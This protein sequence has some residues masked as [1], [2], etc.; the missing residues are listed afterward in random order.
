MSDF[1]GGIFGKVTG[2]ENNASHEKVWKK[3]YEPSRQLVLWGFDYDNNPSFLIL[4]GIQKLDRLL[5]GVQYLK[6]EIIFTHYIVAKGKMGHFPSLD[7]EKA[8][9]RHQEKKLIPQ[10][11]IKL[12]CD[13]LRSNE[14]CV[15]K[16]MDKN[17]YFEDFRLVKKPNEVLGLD[18]QFISYAPCIIEMFSNP[19]LYIR[20]KR[21]SELLKMKPSHELYLFLLSKGSS[22]LISGL[23]LELA[24]EKDPVL[25]D[26]AKQILTSDIPWAEESYAK[27]I[28]R[29][30]QIYSNSLDIALKQERIKWIKKSL[31]ALNLQ[32]TSVYGEELPED[33]VL[34][35]KTY[36][37][38]FNQGILKD[39]RYYYDFAQKKSVP[40]KVPRTFKEG[41]YC[42]GH[43]FSQ[44]LFKNT[45][46]EAEAYELTDV[47]GKLAYYLDSPGLH[48]YL[49]ANNKKGLEY[50]RRYMRRVIDAYAKSNPRKF[51]DIMKELL[52]SYTE[53]DYL[54]K[55]KGSFGFNYFIRYYL[56][57]DYYINRE[58]N[59]DRYQ[60][61]EF[62]LVKYTGDVT[63]FNDRNEYMKGIWDNHLNI[64][65]EIACEAKILPVIKACYCILAYS[66]NIHE[67]LANATYEQLIKLASSK[68]EPLSKA[69]C[70]ILSHKINQIYIFDPKLMLELLS[71]NNEK[72]HELAMGY[73][74]R[75]NASFTP[76]TIAGFL[77]LENMGQWFDIFKENLLSFKGDNYGAFVEQV[78]KQKDEFIEKNVEISKEVEDVLVFSLN[79]AEDISRNKKIAIIESILALLPEETRLPEWLGKFLEDVVFSFSYSTLEDLIMNIRIPHYGVLISARSKRILSVLDAVK[80]MTIPSDAVITEVLDHGS[81]KAIKIIIDIIKINKQDLVRRFST[82]VIMMEASAAILNEIAI[83]IFRDMSIHSQRRLHAMLIDSPVKKVYSFALKELDAIYGDKIPEEFIVHML[84]HSTKEVKAYI[85]D[86]IDRVI[87]RF[88][89]QQA[90]L[91][92]YYLRTLILLPNKVAKGKERLYQIIP[93]FVLRHQEKKKEIEELLLDIG[94][95]N[96]KA[97]SERAL[98][99]LAKMRG[100]GVLL[101]G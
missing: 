100:E 25:L 81:Q 51:M 86:K 48:Y 62:Q 61:R 37:R 54:G 101:E 98:V 15:Q 18:S 20:K 4:Y 78:I 16:I 36:R 11:G 95:S 77:L 71:S 22:E 53:R 29:C 68:Y 24:K 76:Q 32:L 93:A 21:L 80:R 85:S 94:S 45:I 44:D 31:P 38:Y 19:K 74:R 57:Y 7:S 14:T 99:T 49:R 72:I 92:M 27:G 9:T 26:E 12:S 69:F 87:N 64:V 47:I 89:S 82:L 96:V 41:T 55:N 83:S 13:I 3:D 65:A 30:V 42:D 79:Q 58:N 88:E 28:K 17:I 1:F 33:V 23:F 75:T 70:N 84:E 91:F 46:Q 60:G 50:F 40:I 63:C 67:F 5:S 56:Y 35:G 2:K 90:D 34:E 6:D 59:K 97:D 43:K 66:P 10:G 73:F 39:Y 52:T 8:M